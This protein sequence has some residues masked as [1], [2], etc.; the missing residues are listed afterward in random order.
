MYVIARM[1]AGMLSISNRNPERRNAGRNPEI[2][3]ACAA[4]NWFFAAAEIRSPWPSAGTRNPQVIT[5][6]AGHEPLSGTSK[7]V[8]ARSVQPVVAIRPRPK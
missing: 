3:A 4:T 2:T 8:I 7:I 6:S 1:T 5:R